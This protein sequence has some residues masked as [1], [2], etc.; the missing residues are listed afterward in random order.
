VES[1]DQVAAPA[2]PAA[3]EP[4]AP[5]A[6][7]AV[8]AAAEAPADE[9]A[10][11]KWV[12]PMCE[13][14]EADAAG[15]CPKCGMALV[16]NAAK[17]CGCDKGEGEHDHADCPHQKGGAQGEHDHA[18]CPHAKAAAEAAEAAEAAGEAA[19]EAHDHGDHEGHD[20]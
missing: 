17:A 19:P 18:D 2:E 1:T 8:V 6:G 5:A 4:A 9:A 7:E 12:C 20:H 14:V 3:E 13:G 11:A 16:E 15:E 10:A